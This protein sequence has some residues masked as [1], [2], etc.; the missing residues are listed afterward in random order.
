MA[1]SKN[2]HIRYNILD[3]FF[4]NKSFNFDELHRH[5]NEKIAENSPGEG[6]SI[7]T[8]RNDIKVFRSSNNG[9][10][11]PLPIGI[12]LYKYS[13]PTF[14][15]A[16]RPL[17]D[18]ENYLIRSAQELL[19]RFE[20]HPKY[21][22]LSETL[23]KFQDDNSEIDSSK[24]LFFDNNE[25]YK[26][27]KHLKPLFL[28]ITK[29]SVLNIEFKGFNSLSSSS[30]E[31]HPYVLKQYNRR[32]FVFGLNNNRKVRTWSVPLDERLINIEKLK[33]VSY[34]D[35]DLDWNVFFRPLVGVTRNDDSKPQRV[36]LR[37]YNGRE[38]YFK[39]KPFSP[40]FDEFFEKNKNDQVWFESI[41]NKELVQQILSYGRDVEVL[42]PLELKI[43]LQE[44]MQG[45]KS[46]YL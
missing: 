10:D 42:E 31:F 34:I 4:R 24:I 33:D 46:F 37:F 16:K 35:S 20:S 9:F 30:F 44:H 22:M 6:V 38:N 2:S 12:K 5:L 26:G 19:E 41:I 29:K 45:M 18:Y 14:S 40:D 43:K 32:W 36:V 11:A 27:I 25:E 39:T 7:K 8:L 17:L 21:N 23:I 3:Y 1:N 13:D 28:A 15:I